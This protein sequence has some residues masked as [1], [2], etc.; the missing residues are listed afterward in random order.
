MLPKLAS[1]AGIVFDLRGYPTNI[2]AWILP[3]LITTPNNDHWMHIANI[4]GPFGRISGWQD[5]G[6]RM[7]RVAP[8]RRQACVVTFTVPSGFAI[9]FTGM[10]VTG[11]DG[12]AQHHLVG[13]KPDIQLEPTIAGVL[14]NERR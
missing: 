2:G 12:R 11:H 8:S 5:F 1:A 13:V 6:W 9:R 10:L 3:Y 14:T 4:D 7:T